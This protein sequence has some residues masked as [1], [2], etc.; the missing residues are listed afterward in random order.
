MNAAKFTV[1]RAPGF[2]YR[3][4]GLSG[5]PTLCAEGIALSDLARSFGTPLYVYS[6]TTIE[7]RVHTFDRAF[8]RFPHL[9]CYAVKANSSLGLLRL[10]GRLGC[11]FDI[12]SGGEL[13]RVLRAAPRAVSRVVFSGVGK[14]AEEMTAALR[15]GVLLFNVESEAELDALAACASRLK[16]EARI[17]LRVNPNVPAKTHPHISTGLRSHKFGV[18]IEEA[19]RLYAWAARQRGLQVSGVSVHI[20]SQITEVAPFGA[21]MKRVANLV[22]SLQRDGHVIRYVDAGGGLGI[23]YRSELPATFAAS[24][25]RY[26]RT[27]TRPLAGL[28]V[29]LL[30]EPGRVLIGPAGLLLTSVI[31][32]KRNRKKNFVI[33][34]AAMTDLLRPALYHAYHEIVPVVRNPAAVEL[35]AD[36][37]GPVCESGDF[38]GRDR[39]LPRLDPGDLLAVLDAGAYGSVLSS[40]YNSRCRAAEVLVRGQRIQ[41]LRRRETLRDLLR[42]DVL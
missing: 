21:A 20:G 32:N 17:A 2:S 42:H 7:T 13:E 38:L 37:V 16:K 12:V 3:K 15:A 23:P 30:L 40:N 34:D 10:L 27:V 4:S 9:L 24:T 22:R 5:P 33:V 19:P 39:S 36:V 29:R 28:N 26:V 31:Y 41:L 14:T 8:G 6:A 1:L 35:T 18:P 11:G 25:A